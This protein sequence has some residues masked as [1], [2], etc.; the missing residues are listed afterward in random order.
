MEP[1][2]KQKPIEVGERNGCNFVVLSEDGQE[3]SESFHSKE[4]ALTTQAAYHKAVGTL[5]GDL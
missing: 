5:N 2:T 4:F 1:T 3:F